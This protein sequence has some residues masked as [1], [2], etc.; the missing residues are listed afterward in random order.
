MPFNGSGT[1]NALPPPTYP[2]VAGEVIYAARFNSVI[3]DILDGLSTCLA[4]D[5]QTLPTAN[6]N[7]NGFAINNAATAAPGTSTTQLATTAFVDISYLKISVAAATYA[8]LASPAFTG[9][10]T[11]PTQLTGDN[12][13]KLATTAFVQQAAF[14][15]TLPNQTG[16]SGKMLTTDGANASWSAA[17]AGTVSSVGLAAP[18]LF[19]VTNSPVTGSGTLTLSYSG[20]ALPAVNGGTGIASYAIGDLLYASTTSAL[21]KL[22]DVATGSVLLSG[23]LNTAPLWGKVSLTAAV[24]GTL[25]VGNGGTGAI[26]LTGMVKGNGTSALTA[27]TAG[28]DY[29]APGTTTTFSVVQNFAASGITLKGSG[30]GKTTFFSANA[31]VTDYTITFPAA[32]ATL[33][34]LAGAET[35]TNKTLTSPALGDSNITGVKAVA[36]TA[37]FDNGNS[38]VADTV[39]LAAGQ[40]QKITLTGNCT[41]TISTTGA[42]VGAYQLRLIQDATGG[43]TVTWSGLTATRWLG[44]TSAPAINAAVNGETI[45]TMYFDGTNITQSA[46]KVGAV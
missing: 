40:K 43:R 18:A 5:G 22:A 33:A 35:L 31:S 44:A 16:N 28:T 1:F 13:T 38:G 42:T 24:S 25:P 21:A 4:K 6:L 29:V 27:A 19:T 45:I 46:S 12:S 14:A 41:I 17:P 36:F 30:T 10:P 7:L 37:E 23:G 26:T 20:T 15:S 8:G 39:K 9:N 32:T 11:A 3:Q 34:T 2:A